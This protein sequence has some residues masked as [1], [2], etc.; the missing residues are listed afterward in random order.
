[1][2]L[3]RDPNITVTGLVPDTRPYL[4]HAQVVVAPLRVARGIQNKVLEGMAMG[5]SVVV[6][7]GAAEGIHAGHGNELEVASD[8]GEFATKSLAL[9]DDA[10]RRRRMGEAARERVV[11]AYSWAA[12]LL[13][14]ASLLEGDVSVPAAAR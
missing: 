1:M 4:Q 10:P 13:P 2:A 9:M 8:A 5:R 3:D 7:T 11:D 12:N 6:S 14:F